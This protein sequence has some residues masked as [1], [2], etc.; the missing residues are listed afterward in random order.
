MKNKILSML[1]ALSVIP[2]TNAYANDNEYET[3]QVVI[4]ASRQEQLLEDVSMNIDVITAEDIEKMGATNAYTLLKTLNGV[5]ATA[6]GHIYLRGMGQA[7]TLILLDG[8][9]RQ[10]SENGTDGLRTFWESINVNNIERIE[11]IQGAAAVMYGADAMGGVINIITKKYTEPSG[12]VVTS[13]TNHN[14]NTAYSYDFG[15]VDNFTAQVYGGF[16]QRLGTKIDN[17]TLDTSTGKTTPHA[18]TPYTTGGVGT[19]LNIGTKLGYY[20]NDE[21]DVLFSYDYNKEQTMSRTYAYNTNDEAY[22]TDGS[23]TNYYYHNGSLDFQGTFGAHNYTFTPMFSYSQLAGSSS[24]TSTAS[25]KQYWFLETGFDV[26]DVFALNDWN[27][28]T[29]GGEYKF[30]TLD[31]AAVNQTGYDAEAMHSIGAFAQD[32][33]LLL[34]ESLI[35]LPA[36]RFDYNNH[37]EPV[38]TAKLGTTYEFLP[39]QRIKFNVGNAFRLPTLNQLTGAETQSSGYEGGVSVAEF[40]NEYGYNPT[41]SLV[42]GVVIGNT[43]TDLSAVFTGSYATM[44]GQGIVIGNKELTPEK[45]ISMDARYEG[46]FGPFSASVGGFYTI[47]DSA[48]G[49]E[50]LGFTIYGGTARVLL[51]RVNNEGLT[52][53]LGAEAEFAYSYS[54]YLSASL[55]YT[56]YN[57]IDEDGLRLTG[58]ATH[59]LKANIDLNYPA[60]DVFACLWGDL[61]Y[62]YNGSR[63]STYSSDTRSYEDNGYDYFSLNASIGKKFMD[64]FT[65]VASAERLLQSA[66]A[67]KYQEGDYAKNGMWV[68]PEYKLTFTA[69]F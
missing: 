55:G 44:S 24:A 41:Y 48:I 21:H 62:D 63:E 30:S 59:A 31:H 38:F 45:A 42:D 54:D 7:Y 22:R 17:L 34:N 10:G 65:I 20:F 56:W 6:T 3:G 47:K 68:T 67:Y 29:V 58:Y 2:V 60:W 26:L 40:F 52:Y 18:T 57:N 33:I 1:L 9:R 16:K 4:S 13:L 11:V 66:Y 15:R 37:S 28:L 61:S 49:S 35:L 14:L 12:S 23:P 53:H 19:D 43:D 64:K 39:S 27:L 32:E 51:T 50:A 5:S 25:T 36:L 46:E 8:R 69:K